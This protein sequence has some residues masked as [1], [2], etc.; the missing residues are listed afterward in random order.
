ML[1]HGIVSQK[2]FPPESPFLRKLLMPDTSLEPT[3]QSVQGRKYTR[4]RC[5]D[6]GNASLTSK[7]SPR[8]KESAHFSLGQRRSPAS[9]AKLR[10]PTRL[11]HRG[12]PGSAKAPSH[13]SLS[14]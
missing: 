6:V 4:I 8:E 14:I 3:K 5:W 7:F 9:G 1:H 2:K 13:D 10:I 11:D 12:R